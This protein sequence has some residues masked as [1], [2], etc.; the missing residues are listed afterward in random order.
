MFLNI[1]SFPKLVSQK[2]PN[3]ANFTQNRIDIL[4]KVNRNIGWN[5]Y[6]KY[7]C[8]LLTISLTETYS[9]QVYLP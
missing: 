8:V 7:P 2:N 6:N 3:K 4:K 5:K 1:T 9:I